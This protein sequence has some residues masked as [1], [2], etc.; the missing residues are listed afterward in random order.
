[1][2]HK[3]F[4]TKSQLKREI[5]LGL[6]PKPPPLQRRI[7]DW[8]KRYMK[9]ERLHSKGKPYTKACIEAGVSYT[10]FFYWRQRYYEEMR[11]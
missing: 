9:V 8:K 6:P 7:S 1:M 5:I 11:G 4:K 2:K 10:T 3:K